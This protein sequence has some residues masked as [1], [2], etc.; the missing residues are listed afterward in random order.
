MTIKNENGSRNV[1]M[2]SNTDLG[3]H[4]SCAQ[5]TPLVSL[6]TRQSQT[7]YRPRLEATGSHDE[8]R[9]RHD[10][11]HQPDNVLVVICILLVV[12]VY[13]TIEG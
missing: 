2:I 9:S 3:Q 11:A 12:A 7:A 8:W 4:V 10:R 6:E 1:H 13:I 5:P